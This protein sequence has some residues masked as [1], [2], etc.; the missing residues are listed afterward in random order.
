MV[1]LYKTIIYICK[2][3]LTKLLKN[4]KVTKKWPPLPLESRDVIYLIYFLFLYFYKN[5]IIQYS[6]ALL[7]ILH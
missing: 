2:Q 5:K 4:N 7:L 6:C 3:N 1:E